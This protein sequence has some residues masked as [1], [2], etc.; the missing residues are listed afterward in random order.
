MEAEQREAD[1]ARGPRRGCSPKGGRRY[2]RAYGEPDGKAQGNFTAP[3]GVVMKTNLEGSSIAETR[4]W[5]RMDVRDAIGLERVQSDSPVALPDDVGQSF[6]VQSRK[7]LADAECYNGRNLSVLEPRGI[8]GVRDT[9]MQRQEGGGQGFE[10]APDGREAGTL[11]DQ[12]RY[13]QHEWLPEAP[14][15]RIREVLGF[16]RFSVRG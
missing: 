9:W 16:L 13:T 6:D 2:K 1:D 14:D 15:S 10:D 4:K 8:T 12:E 3:N 11:N 7:V 5:W